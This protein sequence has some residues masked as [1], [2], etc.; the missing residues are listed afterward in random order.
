MVMKKKK[1]NKLPQWF[2]GCCAR[3]CVCVCVCLCAGVCVCVGCVYVR[4]CVRTRWMW[5]RRCVC[6]PLRDF[7]FGPTLRKYGIQG[8]FV[9]SYNYFSQRKIR[10]ARQR[11]APKCTFCKYNSLTDGKEPNMI[12]DHIF[13]KNPPTNK[14]IF[15]EVVF[16]KRTKI[17]TQSGNIQHH[18]SDHFGLMAEIPLK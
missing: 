12:L 14:N 13:V 4:G 15:A 3:A 2:K 17:K 16:K 6:W 18:L 5:A 11:G 1:R 9:N 10:G 7:N 8:D